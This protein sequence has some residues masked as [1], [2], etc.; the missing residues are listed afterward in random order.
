MIGRSGVTCVFLR[1]GY[2][3]LLTFVYA[4]SALAPTPTLSLAAGSG[5]PGATVALNIVLSSNVSPAGLQWTLNYST[6]DFSS[7]TVNIG[8]TATAAAKQISCST[9]AGSI[10][11]LLFGMNATTI[12]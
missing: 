3:F 9:H 11:G 5:A 12:A 10:T 2:L 7:V 6:I 4:G 8:A 1:K